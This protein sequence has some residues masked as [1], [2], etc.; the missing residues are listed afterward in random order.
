MSNRAGWAD[1]AKGIGILLVVLGHNQINSFEPT[2][3]QFIFSFHMPLFFMLSG[4][5]FKPEIGFFE[6]LKRRFRSILLPYLIVLASIYGT[7]LFFSTMPALQVF[8]RLGKSL[9]FSLP[10]YLEWL[11]LWF[12]PHLFLL[13]IFAWLMVRLI[14]QRLLALWLRLGFLTGLLGVGVLV[15]RAT[16]NL[17]LTLL[18]VPL[19]IGLPWSVDLLLATW[20]FFLLGYE[21]R[22]SLPEAVLRS[23]WT[24]A[25]S[26]LLWLGLN[27]GTPVEVSL[28]SR[29]YGFFPFSTLAALSGSLMIMALGCQVERLGGPLSAGLQKLGQISM[30][31]LI[32]HGQI[33]FFTFYKT[34]ELI[35]N[36]NLAA[37]LAFLVGAGL[38]VLIWGWFM[39]GNPRLA[40]WFGVPAE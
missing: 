8:K 27:L 16:A 21:I 23:G 35:S 14:Y 18:G 40:G 29:S 4:M 33:Q 25:L 10:E 11:P 7:Y 26:S 9:F 6:L 37:A 20:A 5:F 38:P 31:V 17:N 1:A 2:L 34:L 36:V 12:L 22:R 39:R 19:Q 13:N 32:F 24:L 3:R 15:L 30:L 28:A